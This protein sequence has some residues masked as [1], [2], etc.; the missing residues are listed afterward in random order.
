MIISAIEAI[1]VRI[2][3]ERDKAVG[4]AGSPTRLE[5]GGANYRWSSVFPVLYPV[6]FETAL[7]RITLNT[8]LVGW[9]EAQAPLA[10][11][12]VCAIV[13]LLLK[14]VLHGEDFDGSLDR[15]ECIWQRLYATMR[16]RGQTGGFML[17]AI[18]GIDLALWDLAGKIQAKPVSALLPG[19]MGRKRVQA[20]C[21]GLTGATSEDRVCNAIERRAEG[22]ST[23]KLFFDTGRS[24]F[25]DLLSMLREKLGSDVSLAVD[26]LWRLWPDD[27]VDFGAQLDRQNAMW[28]EA[29]LAPEDPV[30]HAELARTIRTPL[31]LGESY[32]THY[33][34]APFFRLRAMGFVQPDL[35]RSGLT[36]SLK[37]ASIAANYGISVVPHISIAMGPQIAAAIHLAAALPG[38]ELLEYNP[39]VL[40]VAN[41]YLAEPL[42]CRQGNYIVP[43]RPGLGC[44]VTYPV[45]YSI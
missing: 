18:S 2:K 1:P 38:C 20:Y 45:K 6:H 41:R 5:D 15:I 30:A 17:D 39:S 43:D 9:G 28:L 37:I 44:D 29:P 16:V 8:G 13:D 32:R 35:G 42:E 11:E 4:S 21:S 34:L 31:A 40:E 12:V 10:P 26:A 7:V 36:E 25:L 24:E 14:P 23:F 3:R 22:F 27:A 19:T 33:E